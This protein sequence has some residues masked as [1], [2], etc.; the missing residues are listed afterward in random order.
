MKSQNRIKPGLLQP[1]PIPER[2]WPQITA[3]L[4]TDVPDSGGLYGDCDIRGQTDQNGSFCS[5]Y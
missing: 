3:D 1:I 4:V 5:L 2:K